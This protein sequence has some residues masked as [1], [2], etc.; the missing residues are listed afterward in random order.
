[1]AFELRSVFNVLPESVRSEIQI[2]VNCDVCSKATDLNACSGCKLKIYCT[3]SCQR[4]AWPSHRDKCRKTQQ[5]F[6]DDATP[7]ACA[8]C[9]GPT[10]IGDFTCKCLATFCSAAC[11]TSTPHAPSECE[12]EMNRITQKTFDELDV[13]HSSTCT[14]SVLQWSIG[15]SFYTAARIIETAQG[16]GDALTNSLLLTSAKTG[17]TFALLRIGRFTDEELIAATNEIAADYRAFTR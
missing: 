7:Y 2:G 16:G 12:A 17:Y 1:M 4:A 10:C 11:R 5:M 15:K 14:S 3:T 13:F 9:A 6:A 8:G